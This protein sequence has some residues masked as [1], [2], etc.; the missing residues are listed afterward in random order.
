MRA[1]LLL[2]VPVALACDAGVF[3][4]S[5]APR[6]FLRTGRRTRQPSTAADFMVVLLA[7]VTGRG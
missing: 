6:A 4:K 5:L 7:L 3:C 2:V 1:L